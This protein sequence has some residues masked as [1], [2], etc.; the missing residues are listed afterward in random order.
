LQ[1]GGVRVPAPP[2]VWNVESRWR[3]MFSFNI[4]ITGNFLGDFVV[5]ALLLVAG[6]LMA[7][8]AESKWGWVIFA[9]G[10]AWVWLIARFLLKA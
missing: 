10:G 7:I 8:K 5:A 2:D 1:A 9:L 4:P 6:L 3:V